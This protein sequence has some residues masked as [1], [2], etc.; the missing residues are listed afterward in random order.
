[1]LRALPPAS[2]L[3]LGAFMVSSVCS[4]GS[5]LISVLSPRAATHAGGPGVESSNG[6]RRRKGLG[7]VKDVGVAIIEIT[8]C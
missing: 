6:R 8:H 1:M 2:L 7:F 5:V 3:G 4:I